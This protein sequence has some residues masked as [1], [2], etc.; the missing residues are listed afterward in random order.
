MPVNAKYHNFLSHS[1]F[2]IRVLFSKW[3]MNTHYFMKW[4]HHSAQIITTNY[5]TAI[6]LCDVIRSHKFQNPN[7]CCNDIQMHLIS[8]RLMVVVLSLS[9][10]ISWL[11]LSLHRNTLL[12]INVAL[13]APVG[14]KREMLKRIMTVT[15]RCISVCE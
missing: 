8:S 10:E 12:N 7:D 9:F 6:K 11:W 14:Y 5:M 3:I 15:E 2:V 4:I 13:Y 1:I